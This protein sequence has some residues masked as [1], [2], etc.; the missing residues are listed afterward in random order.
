[1]RGKDLRDIEIHDDPI[2]LRAATRANLDTYWRAQLEAMEHHPRE[3]SQAAQWGGL[4]AARLVHLLVT[5]RAG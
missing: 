1:L 4:G 3:A 2:A 5:G